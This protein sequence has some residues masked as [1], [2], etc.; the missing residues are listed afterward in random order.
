VHPEQLLGL[1]MKISREEVMRVAD[2][3]HLEF[4][5]EEISTYQG[6]LDE[7]LTYIEKLNEIDVTDVEPMTQ[8]LFNQ[9]ADGAPDA[10]PE[11]RDD[12]L[13]PCDAAEAILSQAPDAE[14]PFFR[15]P[16][17]IER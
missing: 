8:V 7:V 2:L 11:L 17:V 13:A 6:Q 9:N 1:T 4:T 3:A 5:A 12:V 16:K 15:V 14:K 10:H